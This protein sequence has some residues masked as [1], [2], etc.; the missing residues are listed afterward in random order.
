MAYVGFYAADG[1]WNVHVVDGLS[2]VDLYT[3]DGCLN[4]TGST[5]GGYMHPSGAVNVTTAPG[6]AIV[7]RQAPDGSLYINSVGENDG[8]QKVT[9]IP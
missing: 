3:A 6:G 2:K 9:F 7:P 8:S 1:S 5:G 4:V